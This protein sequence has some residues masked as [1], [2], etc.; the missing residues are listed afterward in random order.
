MKTII[1][2]LICLV[3]LA[4][5]L[6][7]CKSMVKGSGELKTRDFTQSDFTEVQAASGFEVKIA[8]GPSFNV[9]NMAPPH[10]STPI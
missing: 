6:T 1:F 10:P 2:S 9:T 7:S 4:F 8:Y 5:P 3:L